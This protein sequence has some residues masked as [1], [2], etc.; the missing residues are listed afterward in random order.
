MPDKRFDS[1]IAFCIKLEREDKLC[2]FDNCPI[3]DKCF[4]SEAKIFKEVAQ[5]TNHN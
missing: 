2:M 5:A 3:F 4:P 1:V